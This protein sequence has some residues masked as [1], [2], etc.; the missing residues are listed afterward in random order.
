MTEDEQAFVAELG[1]DDFST[2]PE[3]KLT[4]LRELV[5]THKPSAA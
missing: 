4:R 5:R 1:W 2:L 3:A